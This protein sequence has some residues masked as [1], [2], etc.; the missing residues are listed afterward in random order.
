M[1]EKYEKCVRSVMKIYN[2]IRF[3]WEFRAHASLRK[4]HLNQDLKQK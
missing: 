2:G 1:K 3:T 4:W